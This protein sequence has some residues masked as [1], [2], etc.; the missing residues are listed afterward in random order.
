MIPYKTVSGVEPILFPK[1]SKLDLAKY[2]C[3]LAEKYG[4]ENVITGD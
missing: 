1:K 4:E 2:W 3:I